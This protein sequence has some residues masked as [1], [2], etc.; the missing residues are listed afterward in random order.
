M[1]SNGTTNTT[2]VSQPPP[3]KGKLITILSIDG[4]GI[5]GLIPATIIAYLEAKLQVPANIKTQRS[6]YFFF[7][8]ER[9][10]S[11]LNLI[12]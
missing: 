11:F 9:Y 12:R 5:R 4:G 10:A 1:A 3:C 6:I 2:T 7:L 8:S